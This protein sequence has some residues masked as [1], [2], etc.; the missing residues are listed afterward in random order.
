M[1]Y[2]AWILDVQ[3]QKLSII[4]IFDI[5]EGAYLVYYHTMNIQ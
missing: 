1:S 2:G 5:K 3:H 4:F